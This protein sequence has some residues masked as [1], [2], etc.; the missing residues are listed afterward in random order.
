MASIVSNFFFKHFVQL[1]IVC[2]LLKQTYFSAFCVSLLACAQCYKN[3]F[4]GELINTLA[5]SKL[6]C[7]T[8][9]NIF[10]A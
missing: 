6:A 7:L 2:P 3:F 5:R 10:L 4:F 8:G 1:A 9:I